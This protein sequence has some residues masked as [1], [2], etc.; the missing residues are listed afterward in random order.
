MRAGYTAKIYYKE[1][2]CFPAWVGNLVSE[3]RD[4]YNSNMF[5]KAMLGI[6]PGPV[7]S[8]RSGEQSKLFNDD[9]HNL[10]PSQ[11]IKAI[12]TSA[13]PWKGSL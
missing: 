10:Y 6:I 7:V 5:G 3:I 9:L 4:E 12:K 8:R 2:V 1:K 11:N 13:L